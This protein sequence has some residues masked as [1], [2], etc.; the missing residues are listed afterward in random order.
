MVLA[1]FQKLFRTWPLGFRAGYSKLGAGS[2]SVV[3]G[4]YSQRSRTYQANERLRPQ[5][6]R[7][8]HFQ[9]QALEGVA[10]SK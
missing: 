1:Q 4:K 5:H 6:M 7:K 8:C 10:I 2:D 9:W 3:R